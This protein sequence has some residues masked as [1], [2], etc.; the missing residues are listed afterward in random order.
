MQRFRTELEHAVSPKTGAFILIN[1][2]TNNTVAAGII[3]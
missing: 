3:H 2:H 1:E